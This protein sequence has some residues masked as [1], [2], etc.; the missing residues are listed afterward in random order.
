MLHT[1]T[2]PTRD[3]EVLYT[4]EQYFQG[5]LQ[6]RN[7][8]EEVIRFT[9]N[10]ILK[11]GYVT[12]A[13][14]VKLPNGIDYYLSSQKFLRSLGK[15]LQKAFPGELK[16]SKKLFTRNRQTSKDVY[17]GAVLFRLHPYKKGDSITY[18]GEKMT[19]ISIGAKL[20]LQ[21]PDSKKKLCI[22]YDDP[23][24]RNS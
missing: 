3:K 13:K 12:V 22:G 10:A 21:H 1:T 16:E 7:P 17:R 2:M 20:T 24:I 11:T 9:E 14:I 18:K 23:Y 8:T 4:G 6:L 19:V 5:T 15:R